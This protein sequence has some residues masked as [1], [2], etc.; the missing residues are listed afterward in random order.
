VK[1]TGTTPQTSAPVEQAKVETA[2]VTTPI[3]AEEPACTRKIKVV[4]A[5]YGE[6]KGSTCAVTADIRR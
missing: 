6:G 1:A 5:G 3:S 2:A 4:Y